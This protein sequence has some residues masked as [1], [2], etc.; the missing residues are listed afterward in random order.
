MGALIRCRD[1]VTGTQT[2]HRP[3]RTDSPTQKIS[4]A[5]GV[6]GMCRGRGTGFRD[7]LGGA[8]P[9]TVTSQRAC[10]GRILATFWVFSRP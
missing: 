4:A 10:T 9:G 2:S 1:D 6:A 8:V 3:L 7:A 5:G